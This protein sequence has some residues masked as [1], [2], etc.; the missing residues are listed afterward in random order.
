MPESIELLLERLGF[1]RIGKWEDDDT[2]GREGITW[3]TLL[4]ILSSDQPHRPI[5]QIEG[6]RVPLIS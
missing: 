3:T 2:L 4:F 1:Q 6:V 5:D